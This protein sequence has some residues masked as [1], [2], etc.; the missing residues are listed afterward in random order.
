METTASGVLQAKVTTPR[1]EEDDFG[2]RAQVVDALELAVS[3]FG[4]QVLKAQVSG[5]TESCDIAFL[6]EIVQKLASNQLIGIAR[7]DGET[8]LALVCLEF[9]ATD[10]LVTILTGGDTPPVPQDPT[11]TLT[12]VDFQLCRR[13]VDALLRGFDE[14]LRGVTETKGI[15]MFRLV[16]R[17]SEPD[18]LAHLLPN[19]RYLCLRCDLDIGVHGRSGK[20]L[21]ALPYFLLRQVEAD[22]RARAGSHASD[23]DRRWEQHM[24]DVA[25][26]AALDLH[27]VLHRLRMPLGEVEALAVDD[28]LWLDGAS[29]EELVLD[30]LAATPIEPVTRGD[31][32]MYRSLK[33]I[34]FA[35]D[36]PYRDLPD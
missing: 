27:C 14:G 25:M 8:A 20:F 35:A 1:R 10:H 34:R 3:K 24:R 11:R 4:G 30:V 5:L 32:G 17:E 28:M 19:I 31:L 26:I 15:G 18:G 6:P 22:F 7:R 36:S 13:F 29:V 9:D 23:E 33:A 12:E 16:Q 2:L 21:L